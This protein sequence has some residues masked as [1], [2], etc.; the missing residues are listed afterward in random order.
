[1][2]L[3]DRE[4]RTLV[5]AKTFAGLSP[6]MAVGMPLLVLDTYRIIAGTPIAVSH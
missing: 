1:V 5:P 3:G 6:L 4:V 2:L